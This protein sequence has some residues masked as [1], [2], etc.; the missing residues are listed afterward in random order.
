MAKRE[1]TRREFLR[2]SAVAVAGA[3]TAA[4]G[5]KA[6]EAPVV[7]KKEEAAAPTATPKPAEPKEEKE[8]APESAYVE[9]PMIATAGRFSSPPLSS[10]PCAMPMLAPMHR[11]VSIDESGGSAASV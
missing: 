10:S 8:A 2:V 3:V 1:L 9:S 6:T 7:E 5:A 11:H 4:C